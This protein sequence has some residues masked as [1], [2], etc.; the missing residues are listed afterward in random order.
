MG[1][2]GKSNPTPLPGVHA[3]PLAASHQALGNVHGA[4]SSPAP[5]AAEGLEE[6]AMERAAP[7]AASPGS[8]RALLQGDCPTPH[9]LHISCTAHSLPDEEA[10]APSSICSLPWGVTPLTAL[11]S[12]LDMLQAETPLLPAPSVP[13]LGRGCPA[14][15]ES[16]HSTHSSGN[17]ASGCL[18]DRAARPGPS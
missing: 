13:R 1:I 14:E 9:S 7:G 8:R 4:L 11:V 12:N 10:V 6:L 17:W 16:G 3:G 2:A 15:Q 18:Q 5:Q